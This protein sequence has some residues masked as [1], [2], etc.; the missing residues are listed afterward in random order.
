MGLFDDDFYSTKVS[1][2]KSGK[3]KSPAD[4]LTAR[5]LSANQSGRG[6]LADLADQLC[7]QCRSGCA[8]VQ[9]GNGTVH[10]GESPGSGGY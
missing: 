2:R 8:A 6:N 10:H 1:R 9:S 4:M 5:G 3:S 7:L